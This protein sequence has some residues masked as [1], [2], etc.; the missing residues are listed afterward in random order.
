MLP[1]VRVFEIISKH[2]WLDSR[3]EGNK[4]NHYNNEDDCKKIMSTYLRSS[5]N[6]FNNESRM[7]RTDIDSHANIVLVGKNCSVE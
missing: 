5:M 6:A 4:L 3:K 1:D 7:T 2:T